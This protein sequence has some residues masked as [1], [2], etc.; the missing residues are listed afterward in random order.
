MGF[1]EDKFEKYLRGNISLLHRINLEEILQYLPC[2][3]KSTQEKLRQK[4]E[5]RGNRNTIWEFINDLTKRD[6]W[7]QE[8]LY[9][10]R[11]CELNE[12][13]EQLE[14]EYNK[15]V[16]K[17]PSEPSRP[18]STRQALANADLDNGNYQQ[19]V[20]VPRGHER[21]HTHMVIP[22]HDDPNVNSNANYNQA[23]PPIIYVPAKAILPPHQQNQAFQPVYSIQPPANPPPPVQPPQYNPPV[24]SSNP[25]TV[26]PRPQIRA[27]L[28]SAHLAQQQ[29][30][31]LAHNESEPPQSCSYSSAD[32]V[33]SIHSDVPSSS[34]SS[35]LQQNCSVEDS[36]KTPI[37][38]TSPQGLCDPFNEVTKS[39][40]QSSS[41]LDD[42]YDLY[43]PMTPSKTSWVLSTGD[44][45]RTQVPVS[46]PLNSTSSPSVLNLERPLP[47]TPRDP[48]KHPQ[49]PADTPDT[50]RLASTA[51]RNDVPNNRPLN[52]ASPPA[53]RNPDPP[54][55]STPREPYVQKV[56]PLNANSSPSA[57]NVDRPLPST[58]REPDVRRK[59]PPNDSPDAIHSASNTSRHDVPR[60]H[61]PN[62]S[63][64]AIR[65]AGSTSRHD[66]SRGEIPESLP[67]R[68]LSHLPR[69]SEVAE[70][71][72]VPSSSVKPLNRTDDGDEDDF[73]PSKPGELVSTIEYPNTR[74][75][76]SGVTDALSGN[77][78]FLFSS[79]SSQSH[80]L[81]ISCSLGNGNMQTRPSAQNI[82]ANGR[83]SEGQPPHNSRQSQQN[84]PSS[85][86]ER[87]RA[88]YPTT[89]VQPEENEM[90]YGNS[91]GSVQRGGTNYPPYIHDLWL[92][93]TSQQ[94][95]ENSYAENTD[96]RNFT[97]IVKQDA[98]LDQ[99]A[100][101]TLP[102]SGPQPEHSG[103]NQG[104]GKVSKDTDTDSRL[105]L[106]ALA[107]VG[108]SLTLLL[109]WRRVR[110]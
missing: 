81:E 43:P 90:P 3:S 46:P 64:D 97:L 108:V 6:G 39:P 110:N 54:L 7:V 105:L 77:H 85:S 91:P 66:V 106:T 58:P 88:E 24:Q 10:L 4:S 98:S 21:I 27:P 37:P 61:P 15:H 44:H 59:H 72:V 36:V 48:D 74:A 40:V 100:A 94:P 29:T 41:V 12:L 9:A 101:N 87:G 30:A 65:F 8:F 84:S 17:R 70:Q 102:A 68:A 67:T 19:P 16:I 80:N 78:E 38:E 31:S 69:H 35:S 73:F 56:S 55:I 95:E 50:S 96:I 25:S 93:S 51:S 82:N 83:N 57:L 11:E 34:S 89:R 62:D 60:R 45:Q 2:L 32:C 92:R 76:V 42:S 75:G 22:S 104:L 26:Q 20:S 23:Q 103:T 107:V 14:E 52:S 86:G 28:G 109:L 99:M 47:S 63:P 13:V 49:R 1:A 5:N 53:A 33:A 79:D 18:A 71:P